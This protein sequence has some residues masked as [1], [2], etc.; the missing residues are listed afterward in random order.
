MCEG[1][2]VPPTHLP[3]LRHML[4]AH[5]MATVQEIGWFAKLPTDGNEKEQCQPAGLNRAEY[6]L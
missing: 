1:T 6:G 3:M 5:A 4:A 2:P